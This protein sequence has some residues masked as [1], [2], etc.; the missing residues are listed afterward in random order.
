MFRTTYHPQT[1]QQATNC[2]HISI[3]KLR[4]YDEQ[5]L[6]SWDLYTN[7][8]TFENDTQ[9]N[10]IINC[11]QF[12]PVILQPSEAPSML[13]YEEDISG[14]PRGLYYH[15][16]KMWLCHFVDNASA[17]ILPERSKY[18]QLFNQEI[19]ASNDQVQVGTINFMRR[20]HTQRDKAIHK[21]VP[22]ADEPYVTSIDDT[23]VTVKTRSIIERASRN[24]FV[25]STVSITSMP[26]L[27]NSTH[28]PHSRYSPISPIEG[29]K[30]N[31][32]P[33]ETENQYVAAAFVISRIIAGGVASNQSPLFC[34]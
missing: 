29:F 2:N 6:K 10:W 27:I 17:H 26:Y 21:L 13:P 30:P 34:L 32:A 33:P 7:K 8:L 28:H 24:K 19:R 14:E 15:S 11:I 23:T 25:T 18:H 3:A 16:G 9:I 31:I 5:H 12:G 20:E 22:M 1:T 4:N